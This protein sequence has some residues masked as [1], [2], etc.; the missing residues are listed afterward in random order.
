MSAAEMTIDQAELLGP[1]HLREHEPDA[2]VDVDGG[3][4]PRLAAHR[5]NVDQFER[6]NVRLRHH[7]PV[8]IVIDIGIG[9]SLVT[10]MQ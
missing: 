9:V 3:I 6:A 8:I 2:R 4:H 7:P 10:I 1:R 5:A